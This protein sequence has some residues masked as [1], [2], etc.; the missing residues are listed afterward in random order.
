MPRPKKKFLHFIT[1][2]RIYWGCGSIFL[3]VLVLILVMALHYKGMRNAMW[4]QLLDVGMAET[5]NNYRQLAYMAKFLSKLEPNPSTGWFDFTAAEQNA[6]KAIERGK[7][8]Y[9]SGD[10]SEAMESFETA[11]NEDGATSELLFWLAITS[12][13]Y[14]EALNCLGTAKPGKRHPKFEENID[15]E[16]DPMNRQAK[17]TLPVT[18][19]HEAPES[20]RRA[21][22]LFTQLL[23]RDGPNMLIQWLLNYC[24]MTLGDFPHGVPKKWRI[25][26]SFI[27]SYYGETAKQRTAD[28]ADLIFIDRA[29]QLGLDTFN[30]GKGVAVEDFDGDGDLDIVTGGNFDPLRF[31]ANIDGSGF[32]DR[33]HEAGFEGIGQVHIITAA[34]FDNDGWMDLFIGRPFP[35][36][37]LLR[38]HGNGSFEEVTAKAGLLDGKLEDEVGFTWASAWGDIDNDGDLDLFIARWGMKIPFLGGPMALPYRQS[39]LFVNQAG[40]FTERTKEFGLDKYVNDRTLI[41]VAFGDLDNDGFLDLV[42]S[43]LAARS[44]HLLRNIQGRRFESVQELGAGFMAAFVDLDHDGIHEIFHGGF[45]DSRTSTQAAVF[46]QRSGLVT[47][48]SAILRRNGAGHYVRDRSYFADSTVPIPTMGCSYGDLDNDGCLDFY[49]GTGNPEGWTVLPNLMFRGNRD[50]RTCTDNA[51]DISMLNGFGTIQK[52]H[53]IVF[54]D[55]DDDGDQDIIS[56]LG[57]MWQ[58][59]RWPNQ[60]FV[61][62]G[63]S[64]N[65]W[66]KIR[67]RGRQTNRFGLGAR[68]TVTARTANQELFVRTYTMDHKTSFGSPPYLAH[69][70]L[71]DA[72]AIDNVEVFWPVS[73]CRG[74]YAAEINSLNTLD[75]ADCSGVAK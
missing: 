55:F 7:I 42:I 47:G 68:I 32:E 62:E 37:L 9:H 31:Y 56:S 28:H 71:L 27:D 72:V 21:A 18:R 19:Y 59:D 58:G 1:R 36:F 51:T 70:G 33:T 26:S 23:E 20:T 73:G 25:K 38:N 46:G 14:G 66:V 16:L 22:K 5:K 65:S 53:G 41:G 54:F 45:T 29:H 48:F 8:A 10:F 6:D 60:F 2:R 35:F 4:Y 39:H 57:G 3:L 63:S 75:E 67:L 64:N 13:R 24:H 49:L 43:G 17:T 52:G 34:D 50:C 40:H 69:I 15:K 11:I 30:A 61:N 74:S 44:S 12:L